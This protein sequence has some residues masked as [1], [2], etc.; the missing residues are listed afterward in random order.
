M[1]RDYIQNEHIVDRYLSGDLMVREAREFEK[2]CLEHPAFLNEMPIPVRLKARLAR[3]PLTDSETGMFQAIPSSATRT[4]LEV[5]DEGF[6]AEE[7][8]EEWK[9]SY[10]GSGGSANRWV[11][12]GLGLALIAAIGALVASAMHSRSLNEQ[13]KQVRRDIKITQM[14]PYAGVQNYRLQLSRT[15]PAQATLSLGWLQPPQRL[16]LT[17]DTTQS[18]YNTFQ[19]TIDKVDGGRVMQIHRIAR[20]SNK[21]LRLTLNSSAFGP[22]DYLLKLDGYTWRGQLQ[23]AGWVRLGLE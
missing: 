11:I 19:I 4:A 3:R 12:M 2:Y 15:Q 21:E 22:G 23:D 6:D 10:A 17:F 5:N 16:D 20:D 9:R 14:Q 7:E 18:T 13:I 8:K 1:D